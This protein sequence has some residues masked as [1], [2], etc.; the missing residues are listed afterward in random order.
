MGGAPWGLRTPG[1][2]ANQNP[3]TPCGISGQICLPLT[4]VQMKSSTPELRV[5][6]P[7]WNW[8]WG[9]LW[10]HSASPEA[11]LLNKAGVFVWVCQDGGKC[12]PRKLL[13][14]LSLSL[15]AS[16]FIFSKPP[17][18]YHI[19]A[20]GGFWNPLSWESSL[21]PLNFGVSL[22]HSQTEAVLGSPPPKTADSNTM[23]YM[24]CLFQG[25]NCE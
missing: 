1:C 17:Q 4:V 12:A 8:E 19:G 23:Q 3:A 10:L 21:P 2:F 14:S 18:T 20:A 22:I 7:V 25:G 15:D 24:F 5:A 13:V 9:E 6:V 11:P 16:S